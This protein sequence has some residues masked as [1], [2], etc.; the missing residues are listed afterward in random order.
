LLRAL[1]LLVVE[2]VAGVAEADEHK[3]DV[4]AAMGA[5]AH[6]AVAHVLRC[7]I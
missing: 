7:V 4:R 1:L 3:V 5:P 2:A 6:A